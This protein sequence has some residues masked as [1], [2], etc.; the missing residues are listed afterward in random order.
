MSA[1]N[2][3]LGSLKTG[4]EGITVANGYNSTVVNVYDY[5][6]SATNLSSGGYPAII[7]LQIAPN[8]ILVEDSAGRR[9]ETPMVISGF[10]SV[11]R[12]SIQSDLTNLGADIKNYLDG[13][14]ASSLGTGCLHIAWVGSDMEILKDKA[15]YDV[16]VRIT[17]YVAKGDN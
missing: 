10:V 12:S 5:P 14:T 7:I 13:L 11:T 3:I 4:L 8:V 2:T 6:I 16:D 15:Q 9:I 17:Y 1:L